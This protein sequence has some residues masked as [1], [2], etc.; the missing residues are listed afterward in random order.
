MQTIP[1]RLINAR[2]FE[3]DFEGKIYFIPRHGATYEEI[4]ISLPDVRIILTVK[5]E[6]TFDEIEYWWPIPDNPM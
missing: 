5:G 3:P 1:Y 6:I 2:E 4:G